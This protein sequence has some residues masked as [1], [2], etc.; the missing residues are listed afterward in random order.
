MNVTATGFDHDNALTLGLA[1]ELAYCTEA[2]LNDNIQ[3]MIGLSPDKTIVFSKRDVQGFVAADGEKIILA[4]RGS[5][6]PTSINGIQDWL[7]DFDALPV[8]LHDYVNN[9][10]LGAKV[11]QGFADGARDVLSHVINSIWKLDPAQK[12]PLFITG[13]SLGGG[14]AVCAAAFLRYDNLLK[15][16]IQ[17]LYTYGQPRVANPTLAAALNAE[18]GSRYQRVV[19]NVDIVPR[20]PPRGIPP[21]TL[22]ADAGTLEWFNDNGDLNPHTGLIHAVLLKDSFADIVNGIAADNPFS[23]II[24]SLEGGLVQPVTDHLLRF[25]LFANPPAV[26]PKSYLVKLAKLAGKPLPD[27]PH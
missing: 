12:L 4:F 5:E 22:Y 21:F 2:Q 26:N 11:H 14:L 25:K 24:N 1:S 6:P 20:V 13:H 9:G 8:N 7:R 17:G 23:D 3:R 15:R 19:N 18:F 27:A 16:E 10:P